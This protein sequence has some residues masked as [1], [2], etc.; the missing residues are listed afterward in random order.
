M[1]FGQ[2]R[3]F[4]HKYKFIVEIDNIASAAFEKCSELEAEIAVVKYREGGSLVATKDPGL[5][6]ITDVTLE[7]GATQDGDLWNWFKSVVDQNADAGGGAGGLGAGLKSPDFKRDLDIVQL[8]R[9]GSELRRWTLFGTWPTKY[10][11]GDW[12][13]EA[14]EVTM[15]KVTLS[16]TT[17][18]KSFGV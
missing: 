11:G 16:V 12:D 15:E 2:P 10:S 13:N 6:E 18:D 17:F 8:D 3:T 4:H 1:P 9:D 14:S 5:I 7:R